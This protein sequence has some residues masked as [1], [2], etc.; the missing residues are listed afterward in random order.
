MSNSQFHIVRIFD[1]IIH[2]SVKLPQ[3]I[4]TVVESTR[5]RGVTSSNS[6][7]FN[8]TN[9]DLDA[10]GDITFLHELD[11]TFVDFSVY[12]PGIGEVSADNSSYSYNNLTIN[13]KS[14]QPLQGNWG[15]LI[16]V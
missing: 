10:N 6:R 13:M 15:I 8:F 14:Y 7:F 16:E 11:R 4:A 5:G 3:P 1:G 9:G 2:S 12:M